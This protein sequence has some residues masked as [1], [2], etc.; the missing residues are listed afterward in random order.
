MLSLVRGIGGGLLGASLGG[1]HRPS[2]RGRDEQRGASSVG[3]AL[4]AERRR[5]YRIGSIHRPE[6]LNFW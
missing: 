3:C 4:R 1:R 2:Q 5:E 6:V